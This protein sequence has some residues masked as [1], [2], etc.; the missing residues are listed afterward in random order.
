MAGLVCGGVGLAWATT[1]VDLTGAKPGLSP[2][3]WLISPVSLVAGLGLLSLGYAGTL[4]AY[5]AM[6]N[7]WRMGINPGEKHTSSSTGGLIDGF[8]IQYMRCRS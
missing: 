2:M 4:W 7:T 1:F 3:L 5:S 8:D 6:G